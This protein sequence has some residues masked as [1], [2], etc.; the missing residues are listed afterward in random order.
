MVVQTLPVFRT[1]GRLPSLMVWATSPSFAGVFRCL[2]SRSRL[3]RC[4]LY[5][6]LQVLRVLGLL[7]ALDPLRHRPSQAQDQVG[8]AAISKSAHKTE[9]TGR[10]HP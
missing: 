2:H 3:V 6:L 4:L 5:F 10:F 7:G 8:E 1:V 9:E